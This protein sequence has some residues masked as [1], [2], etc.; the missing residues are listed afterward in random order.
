MSLEGRHDLG[1]DIM[2]SVV[3]HFFKTHKCVPKHI[4]W[5]FLAHGSYVAHGMSKE[6]GKEML[7]I[8]GI[9]NQ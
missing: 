8:N 6:L 7:L 4:S 9:K 1:L 3:L 5:S 2:S